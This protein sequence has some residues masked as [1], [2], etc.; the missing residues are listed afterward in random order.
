M[1]LVVDQLYIAEKRRLGEEPAQAL[2]VEEIVR[3][4]ILLET[5]GGGRCDGHPQTAFYH[6]KQGYC[7]IDGAGHVK[8]RTVFFQHTKGHQAIGSF[9]G[10]QDKGF[11]PEA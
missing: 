9:F 6:I 8:S 2:V 7:I 1:I 11:V 3:P 4:G 10:F 5:E